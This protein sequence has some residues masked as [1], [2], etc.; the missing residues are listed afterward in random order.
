VKKLSTAA[1]A[2]NQGGS[3]DDPFGAK[4]QPASF[5]SH[6]STH[7]ALPAASDGSSKTLA[8]ALRW[9]FHKL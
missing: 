7:G 3:G 1:A 5:A 8:A 9:I 4:R 2:S 6:R